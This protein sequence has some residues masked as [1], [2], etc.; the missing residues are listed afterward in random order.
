[1]CLED[2]IADVGEHKVVVGPA[3]VTDEAEPHDETVVVELHSLRHAL[4]N[5]N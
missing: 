5:N 3:K 1:M 4:I 2:D